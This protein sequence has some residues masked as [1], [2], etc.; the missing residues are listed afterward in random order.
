MTLRRAIV[1]SVLALVLLAGC[2]DSGDEG[3]AGESSSATSSDSSSA[4]PTDGE[5]LEVPDDVALTPPGTMLDFGQPATIAWEPRIDETAILDVTVDRVERTTFKESF[6]GWV[7]TDEME[8]QTPLFVQATVSNAGED[9][10][11]GEEVPLT[12]VDDTGIHVQPT[13]AQDE[14]FEPCPGGPLPKKFKPGAKT[15]VCLLYLLDPG[16]EFTSVAFQPVDAEHRPVAD[17]IS[18]TGSLT[19]LDDGKDD[20]G[21]KGKKGQQ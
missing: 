8:G 4:A 17:A 1:L 15:K 13:I 21:K 7:I 6:Q 18:W 2:S 10:L 20:Q 14:T 11:G 3:S 12:V 9:R 5:Y 19:P 16:R